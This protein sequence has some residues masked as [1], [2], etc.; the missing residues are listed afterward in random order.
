MPSEKRTSFIYI[1]FTIRLI[2]AIQGHGQRFALRSEV[3]DFCTT[4]L[5]ESAKR[6]LLDVHEK[7]KKKKTIST[8]M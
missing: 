1:S 5:F 8:R 3:N 4:E 7:K 6:V 2:S